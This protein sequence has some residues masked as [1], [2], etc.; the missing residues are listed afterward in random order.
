M[1]VVVIGYGSI[2]RRH[3]RILNE[4]GYHVSIVSK[5]DINY[6]LKYNTLRDAIH[7]EKPEYVVIANETSAHLETLESLDNLRYHHKILVEKPLYHQNVKTMFHFSDL[8]IGYNLRFHPII[9]ALYK[10]LQG[11]KVLSVQAYAGQYLPNWRPSTDYTSSYS[12]DR[13]KGGGVIRDLSH[14][15]DYLQFLFGEW[16]ALFALGGKWSDLAITSDDTFAIVYQSKGC[17]TIN[18]QINYLDHIAQRTITINTVNHTYKADLIN[19]T[20]QI[21]DQIHTYSLD[22]DETYKKQHLAIIHDEKEYLCT[23]DQGLAIVNM[24][25]SAENSSTERAWILNE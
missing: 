9:Q 3:C 16:N 19:N 23:Y 18:L 12:S 6:P 1:N 25:E 10:H 5:R 14:E 13:N 8:Y 24:I 11:Q 20:L 7:T 4:M 2:G 22:A 15:L 17:P 21:N